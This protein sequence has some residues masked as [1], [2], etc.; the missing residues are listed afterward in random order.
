M[1]ITL[2]FLHSN[3]NTIEWS[4][5]CI[6]QTHTHTHEPWAMSEIKRNYFRSTVK[7]LL[8]E[9]R[10]S[11]YLYW[12]IVYAHIHLVHILWWLCIVYCTPWLVQLLC[13]YGWIWRH[14]NK[15]ESWTF[16]SVF[17]FSFAFAF[18]FRFID[19][20]VALNLIVELWVLLSYLS[21]KT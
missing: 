15:D 11:S 8:N 20:C 7:C 3:S 9:R 12:T 18:V 2:C 21:T 6:Y 1:W 13:S 17:F 14:K 16:F 10:L 19:F 5:R 4:K